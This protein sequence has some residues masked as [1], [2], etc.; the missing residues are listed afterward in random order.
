MC[1]GRTSGGAKPVVQEVPECPIESVDVLAVD[2]LAAPGDS[3]G[4]WL[5][6]STLASVALHARES[7]VRP[8]TPLPSTFRRSADWAL[9]A[10]R[11][12][13]R[14]SR[15]RPGCLG[16][17][18]ISPGDGPRT[19]RAVLYWPGADPIES[20]GGDSRPGPPGDHAPARGAAATSEPLSDGRQSTAGPECPGRRPGAQAA[21]A[22]RRLVR[23][24]EHGSRKGGCPSSP[25]DS[26]CVPAMASTTCGSP[27]SSGIAP[28]FRVG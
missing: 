25:I 24:L 10:R 12:W 4:V 14:T 26:R 18:L 27:Q 19:V 11:D 15:H 7:V 20:P 5:D 28:P 8:I 17:G 3:G 22:A 9:R 13:G 1:Q 2:L 21:T 23:R 6:V 16:A